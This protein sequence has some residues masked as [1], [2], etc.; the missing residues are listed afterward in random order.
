MADSRLFVANAVG[1]GLLAA[2]HAVITWP[3]RATLA[4]FAGGTLI[5]FVAE[6]AVIGLGWL[7]HHV[8]P[9]LLGVPVYVLLSW[10]GTVYVA[11]RI[12][13]VTTDGVLAVALAALLATA[14]DVSSDHRGVELGLWT[15]TD[16]VPGP[17]FR[18]VPWWN[19]TGWIV[20]SSL[21]AALALP[22]L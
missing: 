7:E 11:F 20:V 1:I 5:A 2:L 21:T 22:F 4:L 12:A 13:L 10:T 3:A 9:Q 19:Y 15:Y 16:N 8:D 17:R 14:A 18:G 6:I